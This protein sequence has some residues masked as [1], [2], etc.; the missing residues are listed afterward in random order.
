MSMRLS[1]TLTTAAA[2][3]TTQLNCVR[4]A[5]P[6]PIAT[7]M[8]PANATVENA[9]GPTTREDSSNS[10]AAIHSTIQGERSARPVATQVVTTT[11]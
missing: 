5:R 8:Y 7:T 1:A 11:R 2:P 3:V 10:G 4:R 9:S 6:T